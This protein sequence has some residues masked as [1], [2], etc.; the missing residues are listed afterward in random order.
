MVV[1]VERSMVRVCPS[2]K[3][4]VYCPAEFVL[5]AFEINDLAELVEVPA[6]VGAPVPVP[7]MLYV[8]RH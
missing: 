5:P 7:E 3:E 2:L 8:M 1:M 6:I 4:T